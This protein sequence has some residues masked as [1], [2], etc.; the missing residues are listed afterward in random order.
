MTK[1]RGS[2]LRGNEDQMG[3]SLA[4]SPRFLIKA[5][6][7][8]RLFVPWLQTHRPA[9]GHWDSLEWSWPGYGGSGHNAGQTPPAGRPGRQ[10]TRGPHPGK[11]LAAALEWLTFSMW[12]SDC[13][14]RLWPG[15]FLL[16]GFRGNWTVSG[17]SVVQLLC[18]QV[19]R[20]THW[21]RFTPPVIQINVRF[22]RSPLPS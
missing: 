3:N 14:P 5:R 16:G 1:I 4:R 11:G 2:L 22:L 21:W 12:Q 15:D 9:A 19:T 17:M 18:K 13:D 8:G 7:E 20:N 10:K 6:E